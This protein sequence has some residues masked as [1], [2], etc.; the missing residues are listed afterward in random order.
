MDHGLERAPVVEDPHELAVGDA[1]L[2]G[3]FRVN[4]RTGLAGHPP[5]RREIA[6]TRI[7]ERVG[8]GGKQVERV[9]RR[10]GRIGVG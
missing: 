2:S 10:S 3:V 1:P 6:V 9:T 4:E 7:Q 8:L 5:L